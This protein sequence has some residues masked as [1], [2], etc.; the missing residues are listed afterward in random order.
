[1]SSFVSVGVR[2][3][4]TA[5]LSS[6]FIPAA[7]DAQQKPAAPAPARGAIKP[8]TAKANLNAAIDAAKK[9]QAD[10]FLILVTG[11]R[12]NPDGTR[13]YWDYGA[14]SP[15]AKKCAMINVINGQSNAVEA[16]GPECA[17]AKIGDFIDSD[18][19]MT[20]AKQ[21]G[22]TK[23]NVDM[24]VTNSPHTGKQVIWMIIEDGLRNKGD[25]EIDIDAATG[26]VLAV[27]RRP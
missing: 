18:Q 12:V 13:M 20:I 16:G 8:V 4:I 5:A 10:A 25:L 21:N 15:S 11:S 17:E 14:Y 27:D 23:P 6:V 3:L 22:L 7:V 26:K 1:M 19:A 9:W 2:I 24:S